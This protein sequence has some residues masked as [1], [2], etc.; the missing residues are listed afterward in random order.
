MHLNVKGSATLNITDNH[1][2]SD[3]PIKLDIWSN[4]IDITSKANNI[5]CSSIVIS[6]SV[7]SNM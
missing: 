5:S 7:I 3:I 1:V 2:K 4:K 6:N